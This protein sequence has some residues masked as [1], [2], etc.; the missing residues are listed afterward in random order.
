MLFLEYGQLDVVDGAFV[1]IDQAGV[2]V[3]IPVGGL[4]C[5]MLE[6]GTRVSHAAVVFDRQ[7]TL[8]A[9]VAKVRGDGGH[10]TPAAGDLDHHLRRAAHDGSVQ[11][12]A[13]GA[14]AVV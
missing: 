7:A 5:L 1:L 12:C 13:D 2:R 11:A 9:D 3:Q 4:V 14:G 8:L 6:P 10:A